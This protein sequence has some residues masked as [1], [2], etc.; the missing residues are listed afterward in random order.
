MSNTD[1][2]PPAPSSKNAEGIYEPFDIAD[3]PF[4]T[5]SR[6]ERFEMRWQH[7]SSYG[8]GTQIGVAIETLAPG[9]QTNQAHYH[10]LEEEHVF[11]L[12]GELTVR[13][14]DKHHLMKAGHYVCFPAGQKAAHTLI[15]HSDAP[16]RYVLIGNTQPH[17]VIF[18]P[19]TQRVGVKLAGQSFRSTAT[20]DYWDDVVT[21]Q[22]PKI[23]RSSA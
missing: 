10:L 16:C 3:V 17:D 5:F 2:D 1:T 23:P 6:G 4:E 9:K 20:M 14:G 21:D 15:N 22:P 18:Y 7:L 8:G 13:L 19:D 12:E 11:I